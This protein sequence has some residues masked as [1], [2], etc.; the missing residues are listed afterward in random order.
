V[1]AIAELYAGF[2]TRGFR[3]YAT[4]RSAT[5]AG[6]FTNTVF[7]VII[8]YTFIALWEQRPQL[9]GYGVAQALTFCWVSQGLIMPVGLFGGPMVAELS[10]RVRTGAVATDLQRPV[11]LL[12]MR[13]AEDLGRAAYHLLVR[14]LVPLLIGSL[15]FDLAWPSTPL[16][17]LLFLVSVTLAVVVGFSLRYLLGLLA[18]WVVETSG[19]ASLLVVLQIFCSGSLLPLVAFPDRLRTLLE[20][21]PFRC[22]VQVP[23]DVLLREDTGTAALPLIALQLAWALGLLAVGAALTRLAVRLVV[24]HG[25]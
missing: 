4:Y 3:R 25:G 17:W 1:R 15:L 14:G 10:D 23:I 7:G 11:S 12:A 20:A 24:V 9:G 16:T 19:F 8:A 22:M 2:A 5:L 13:L 6:V 21:L 18:F